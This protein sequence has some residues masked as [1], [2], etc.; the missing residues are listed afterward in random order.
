[1]QL[2]SEHREANLFNFKEDIAPLLIFLN[3]LGQ[4]KVDN[5]SGGKAIA[6]LFRFT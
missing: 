6:I 1:L 3:L 2:R 4:L 5:L